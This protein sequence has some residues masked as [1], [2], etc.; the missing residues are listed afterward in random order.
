MQKFKSRTLRI[1][2]K[3]MALIGIFEDPKNEEERK[4]YGI[5]RE[6]ISRKSYSAF[7]R[8]VIRLYQI[9]EL[10]REVDNGRPK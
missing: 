1:K 10:N 4:K 3:F 8:K 5:A 2:P 6:G 9:K 7:V